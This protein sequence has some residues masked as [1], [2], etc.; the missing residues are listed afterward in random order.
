MGT[1]RTFAVLPGPAKV[2][3]IST[4][5]ENGRM[6]MNKRTAAVTGEWL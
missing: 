4:G 2:V 5:D 1:V 6:R 3:S